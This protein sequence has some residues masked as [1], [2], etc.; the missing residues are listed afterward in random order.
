VDIWFFNSG[1]N[2]TPNDTLFIYATNGL[3]DSILLHKQYENTTN[4][5]TLIINDIQNRIKIGPKNNFHFI[6]GDLA[7]SPHLVEAG[8]DNFSIEQS[9]QTSLQSILKHKAFRVY[10]NPGKLEAM[11][12]FD[13][14]EQ[15]R[16]GTIALYNQNG[17][18][19]EQIKVEGQEDI[20][21]GRA[22]VPGLYI[23]LWQNEK[24]YAQIEKWIKV[25]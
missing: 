18:L 6:V 3:G 2:S 24:G 19:Q 1:G 17:Q 9:F 20:R 7:T 5:K 12:Q 11:I 16:T 21:L 15:N 4:W 10:P 22:L 23:I 25:E 8:V 13:E 14:K